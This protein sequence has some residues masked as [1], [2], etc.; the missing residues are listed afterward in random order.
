MRQSPK[1]GANGAGDNFNRRIS[2]FQEAWWG[3]KTREKNK[4]HEVD[5]AWEIV[6]HNKQERKTSLLRKSIE[7]VT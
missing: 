6:G 1:I 3:K 2:E 7:K 4:C 5:V